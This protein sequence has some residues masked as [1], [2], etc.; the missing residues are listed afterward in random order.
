MPYRSPNKTN[1]FRSLSRE[2]ILYKDPSIVI[3]T[4]G[5]NDLFSL[6]FQWGTLLRLKNKNAL[7]RWSDLKPD[8][9]AHFNHNSLTLLHK[10]SVRFIKWRLRVY[11]DQLADL[12]RNSSAQVV[13]HL[14]ILERL[15]PLLYPNLP[16]YMAVLN[17]FLFSTLKRAV[18]YNRF[19]QKIRFQFVNVATQFHGEGDPSILFQDKEI[20]KGIMVHR[21]TDAYK[22]IFSNVR[23]KVL[24]DLYK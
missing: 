9:K 7:S 13:Y 22:E 3:F 21:T 19:G 4:G 1:Q 12:F 11:L 15:M 24:R 17:S 2:I 5:S 23:S 16:M 8:Q 10:K 6:I 20:N 18:I 14:S